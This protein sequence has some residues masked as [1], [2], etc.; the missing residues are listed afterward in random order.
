MESAGKLEDGAEVG[1]APSALVDADG[2]AIDVSLVGK[3]LLGVA[4]SLAGRAEVDPE[5]ESGLGGE[6]LPAGRHG[7]QGGIG[8]G[9]PNPDQEIG[10]GGGERAADAHE[11]GEVGGPLGPLEEADGGAVEVGGSGEAD[12]RQVG[13][14]AGGAHLLA[15]GAHLLVD[16]GVPCVPHE[17]NHRLSPTETPL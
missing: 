6:I 10:G 7:A 2:G 9:E 3:D 11:G 16:L 12:L 15:E 1:F 17:C 5:A 14:Q 8:G 4:G 13:A